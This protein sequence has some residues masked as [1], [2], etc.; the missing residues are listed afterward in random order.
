M[1][2]EPYKTLDGSLITELIRPETDG[3]A[4][5]SLARAVIMPGQSTFLHYHGSSEEIYYVI[6]GEGL[7]RVNARTCEI[8]P[9][10]A[11]LIRPGE[12]HNVTCMGETPLCILCACAPPYRHE[13]T[14]ITE[15]APA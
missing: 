8:R 15:R 4:N 13:D 2:A 6:E 1:R 12:E 11:H 9:G 7:L 10:D 14:V 3:S 5:L